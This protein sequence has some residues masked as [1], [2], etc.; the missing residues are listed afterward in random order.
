[1]LKCSFCDKTTDE[2]LQLI[3]GPNVYIC[4]ECVD[5]CTEIIR[6]ERLKQKCI[7][8]D[9]MIENQMSELMG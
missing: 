8:R 6:E 4:E 5:L 3:V 9:E 7:H 2:I 1:M